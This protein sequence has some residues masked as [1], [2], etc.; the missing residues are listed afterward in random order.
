M[1]PLSSIPHYPTAWAR[2]LIIHSGEQWEDLQVLYQQDLEEDQTRL[3]LSSAADCGGDLVE[4]SDQTMVELFPEYLEHRQDLMKAVM[5]E[6]DPEYLLEDIALLEAYAL[7]P[8]LQESQ[9]LK[10]PTIDQPLPQFAGTEEWG[11]PQMNFWR[12]GVNPTVDNVVVWNNH[13]LLIQRGAQSEAFPGSWALPGGFHD[14]DAHKGQAWIPGRET[15]Q[16]AAWRELH[17][18]TGLDLS[19]LASRTQYVGFFDHPSRD[20]RNCKEAWSVSNAFRID[21]P[22]G[23]Q[24]QVQGLDDAQDARW[25]SLEELEDLSLAFDHRDILCRAGVR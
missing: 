24:P 23:Y 12:P 7:Q 15:A 5:Q 9:R 1:T 8:L 18:E 11:S 14:T 13:I 16:Q 2:V 21:L 3:W 10:D 20:P 4:L 25:V 22:S 19:S 17:E 6:R